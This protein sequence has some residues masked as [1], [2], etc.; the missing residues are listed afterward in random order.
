M[1]RVILL[2]AYL[3]AILTGLQHATSAETNAV[4]SPLAESLVNQQFD[5]RDLLYVDLRKKLK[6]LQEKGEIL[7]LRGGLGNQR[8]LS[9]N[10][11][12]TV[13]KLLDLMKF[14]RVPT[15]PQLKVVKKNIILQASLTDSGELEHSIF[16]KL[17]LEAGDVVIFSSRL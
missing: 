4:F 17:S 6:E 3:A 11:C 15:Q 2:F 16:S 1:K 14:G 13:P 12:N 9:T 10:E 8:Q 5:L 7:V